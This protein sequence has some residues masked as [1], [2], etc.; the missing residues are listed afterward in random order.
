MRWLILTCTATE[1]IMDAQEWLFEKYAPGLP[2]RDLH[3]LHL[4]KEPIH[5]WTRNV[6][7][8]L[9]SYDDEY[10]VFGL[11]D[12]LPIDTLDREYFNGVVEIVKRENLQRYEL[13]WGAS[14]K[15]GFILEKDFLRYG[16]DT[17]YSVSCQFS[18]WNLKELKKLL[19]DN[20][21]WT[22]WQFEVKGK[23]DRVG[24]NVKPVFR[25][26]E[27]SALSGRHPG[28]INIL[29]LRPSDVEELIDLKLIDG[30]KTQYG[31][32]R[33]A[34]PPFDPKNVGRKYQEFYV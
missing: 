18:I 5:K 16:P 12:Y 28:K 22:P 19:K 27:E 23:L 30:S 32:P 8:L 25:W 13:G 2:L 7:D 15:A 20:P 31:M 9:K 26:I 4:Q 34:V 24:C 1:H 33:G 17:Q 3:Y 21:N 14:K 29:G 10:I 6:L 11:D